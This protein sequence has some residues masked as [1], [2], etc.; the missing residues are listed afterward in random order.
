ME[1]AWLGRERCGD[2]MLIGCCQTQ[3]NMGWTVNGAS[4]VQ[5]TQ[6]AEDG[7]VCRITN[8]RAI[9]DGHLSGEDELLGRH[10]MIIWRRAKTGHRTCSSAAGDA[11]C[12]VSWP[13]L[14]CW[15]NS[16]HTGDGDDVVVAKDPPTA[17]SPAA[18]NVA[19]PAD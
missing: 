5:D 12:Q 19:S 15:E 14:H 11:S 9:E 3:L 13:A 18:A 6:E 1:V 7:G 2:G 4:T 16:E 8:S 17:M 10:T